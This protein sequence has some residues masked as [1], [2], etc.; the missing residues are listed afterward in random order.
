MT[1]SRSIEIETRRDVPGVGTLYL[2]RRRGDPGRQIEFIEA[3]DPGTPRS[4]KWILMISTQFGCAVSC[5]MCDAG[6]AGYHGNLTLPELRDQILTVFDARP[7]T[8]AGEVKKLKLHFARMGEPSFNPEVLRCIEELGSEGRLPGLVPSISSVAPSC[9]GTL[10]FFEELF[11]LKERWFSGGRFQLQF[12]VHS[13]DEA[14]RRA[15]IPIRKWDL[16]DIAAVGRRWY[17][18]G[19]R[20]VTLNFALSREAPCD[21][22]IVARLFSPRSFLIKFTP[23]HPTARADSSGLTANWY[24]APERITSLT[25]ELERRG[26]QVIV[27]APWPEEILSHASCGQLARAAA[28]QPRPEAAAPAC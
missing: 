25:S 6:A 2:A 15:L 20:R 7:E 28:E 9:R 14:A 19:D 17:R 23:I 26:Y 13:T 12:S 18:E 4:D 22:A 16:E 27:N 5:A 3:T 11:R 8:A 21:P 10:D 1:Q 24:Q